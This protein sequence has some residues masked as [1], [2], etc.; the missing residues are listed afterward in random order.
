VELS[1]K[2]EALLTAE[3]GELLR[4]VQHLLPRAIRGVLGRSLN[5]RVDCSDFREIHEE[6][7]R[8]LAQEVA[9]QVRRSG[10]PKKLDPMPP[11]DRR[12]IHL[13]LTDEPDVT[14][15]S[16]GRGHYKQVVVRPD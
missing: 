2:D 10:R 13:T 11:A 3:G 9:G 5:V 15:N 12:I 4:S 8:S 7:L 16:E 6:R 1:G 14:S